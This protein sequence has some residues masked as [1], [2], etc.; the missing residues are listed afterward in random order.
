METSIFD[1]IFK[2]KKGNRSKGYDIENQIPGWDENFNKLLDQLTER[3]ELLGEIVLLHSKSKDAKDVLVILDELVALRKK[4]GA[5]RFSQNIDC[6]VAQE[7]L[8][9]IYLI[10]TCKN[11]VGLVDENSAEKV[12]DFYTDLM[13]TIL[14]LNETLCRNEYKNMSW[15][16]YRFKIGLNLLAFTLKVNE[17]NQFLVFDNQNYG[18]RYKNSGFGLGPLGLII[19]SMLDSNDKRIENEFIESAVEKEIRKIIEE[20][21]P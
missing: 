16:N 20:K 4:V 14:A 17:V 7:S 11:I 19:S 3:K 1:K 13:H 2:M 9:V 6:I 21:M 12:F 18:M 15:S 10:K 5:L 8:M